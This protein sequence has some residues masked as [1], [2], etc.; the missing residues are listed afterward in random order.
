MKIQKMSVTH[1]MK[2]VNW[3]VKRTSYNVTL[4]KSNK[5]ELT[6]KNN[7]IIQ[8]DMIM[9]AVSIENSTFCG[10]NC[11][12]CVRHDMKNVNQNMSNEFFFSIMD[13]ICEWGGGKHPKVDAISFV[14][15][16]DAF[17][18]PGVIEKLKYV[19]EK[20]PFKI[21]M[22]NTCEL[23]DDDMIDAV[24]NYVDTLK[25]SHYGMSDSTF[26]AVHGWKVS[27][28]KVVDQINRLLDREHRP[29]VTL[30][31]LVLPE[32]ASEQGEFIDYWEPRCDEVD[33]WTPHNWAGRYQYNNTAN[34]EE[35][36][37]CNRPG[38]DYFIHVD[39]VVSACCLDICQAL[40]LGNLKHQC[41]N[42]IVSGKSLSDIQQKHK[43]GNFA[44]LI[45]DNCDFLHNREDCLIYSSNKNLKV[46]MKAGYESNAVNFFEED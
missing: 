1:G 34:T 30:T 45:C 40:D 37:S 14:G 18:D 16:G 8:E 12:A 10:A 28:K 4:R 29:R 27:R 11:I 21:H 2:V 5:N 32:N 9:I 24:C 22:T 38:R 23:L 3:Q 44:S 41:W 20:T 35:K 15:T 39:G 6:T 42:D 7:R 33:I 25:I 19:K 46:G 17:L 36:S 26:Q 31:F 13:Q 43:E